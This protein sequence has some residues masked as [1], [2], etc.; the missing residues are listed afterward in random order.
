MITH[1]IDSYQIPR[2]SQ[3]Y[4]FKNIAKISNFENWQTDFTWDTPSEVAWLD[5]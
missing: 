4:K 1:T 2:Q 5:V 3:S